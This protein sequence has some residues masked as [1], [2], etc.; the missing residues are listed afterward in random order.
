MSY[1]LILAKEAEQD[2]LLWKKSGQ[3]KDLLK[4]LSLFKELEEHPTTG[5]G[6]VE[7]LRGNLSGYWSRRINKHYRIVYAIYEEVVT[8]EVVSARNHYNDK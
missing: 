4:L 3:K 2:L 1:K 7:Q 8:V 6:Q 5:T